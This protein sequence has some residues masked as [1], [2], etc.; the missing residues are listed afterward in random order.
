MMCWLNRS[1]QTLKSHTIFH[2]TF[3]CTVPCF[4]KANSGQPYLY[5]WKRQSSGIH[6]TD[7]NWASLQHSAA[8]AFSCPAVYSAANFMRLMDWAHTG[9]IHSQRHIEHAQNNHQQILPNASATF[10]RYIPDECRFVKALAISKPNRIHK[11]TVSLSRVQKK[12]HRQLTSLYHSSF[13]DLRQT[14]SRDAC[15]TCQK[16][17]Q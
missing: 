4:V 7:H 14:W 3:Q 10:T 9:G 2:I 11:M 5:M 1:L 15:P 16:D 12:K 8:Y 13:K 6:R 17:R